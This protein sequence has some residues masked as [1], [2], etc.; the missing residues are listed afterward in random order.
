MT[1]N[2]RNIDAFLR[3]LGWHWKRMPD[4]R[5]CQLMENTFNLYGVV[6]S[7]NLEDDVF[8]DMM[9]SYHEQATPEETTVA[10]TA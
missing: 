10:G 7:F 5:L 2:P 3:E 1:R 6:D 8:M 9:R 4:L